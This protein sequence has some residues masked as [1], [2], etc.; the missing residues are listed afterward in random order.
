MTDNELYQRITLLEAQVR[1]LAGRLD[2]DLPDL[3]SLA[4]ADV[5]ET[6]RSLVASGDKMGAVKAYRRE[7][8]V[9]LSAA[10]KVIESL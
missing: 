2:V 5:S 10:L 8:G 9:D 6:V 4:Q 3:A 1:F 7:T